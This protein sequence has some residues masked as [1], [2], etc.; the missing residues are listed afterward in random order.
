VRGAISNDRP[1]RDL[2]EQCGPMAFLISGFWADYGLTEDYPVALVRSD[3][4]ELLHA[5]FEL[6]R[7]NSRGVSPGVGLVRYAFGIEST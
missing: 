7:A 2:T 1:Y 5:A 6:T 4:W 3:F